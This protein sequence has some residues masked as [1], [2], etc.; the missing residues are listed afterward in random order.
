MIVWN[1]LFK[2]FKFLHELR[3]TP[4]PQKNSVHSGICEKL[5]G[6]LGFMAYQPL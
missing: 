2:V 1:F 5:F 6:L 4:P 3:T